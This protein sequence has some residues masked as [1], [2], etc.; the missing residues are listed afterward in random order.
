MAMDDN[1]RMFAPDAARLMDVDVKTIRRYLGKGLLSRGHHDNLISHQDVI[2]LKESLSVC[3]DKDLSAVIKELFVLTIEGASAES[4]FA[5]YERTP[6][7]ERCL[8]NIDFYRDFREQFFRGFSVSDDLLTPGEVMARLKI[9]S[10]SVFR[11]LN[12]SGVLDTISIRTGGRSWQYI[13][14]PV[15][16]DYISSQDRRGQVLFTTSGLS[17]DTGIRV[18]VLDKRIER[19]KKKHDDFSIKLDY[20]RRSIYLLTSGECCEVANLKGYRALRI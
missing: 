10:V 16:M 17:Q 9:S 13:P 14:V 6:A 5:S 2:S 8:A 20:R 1:E 12:R 11:D 3:R 19:R 18:Q 7:L 4:I 15:F